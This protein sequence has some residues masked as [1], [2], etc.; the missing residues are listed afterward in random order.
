MKNNSYDKKIFRLIYILNRLSNRERIIT[1]NLAQEFN[2]TIRTVQRD[3]EL[4]SMTGFPLSLNNGVYKFEE[5]F[6][7]RKISVTPEEKFLLMLFYQ[8]FS[9]TDKPLSTTA[10]NL[11]DKVLV[12][13][14]KKD[15]FF[16]ELSSQYKKRVLKE[17]F[18]N[19]SDSLAVRLEDCTYP[20]L[21]I[22]KIDAFIIELKEKIEALKSEDKVNIKLE[23][24]HRYENNKPIAVVNVPKLY[25]KDKTAKFD[26]LLKEKKDREFI[27]ETHLPG[28]FRK[29]FR[30]SLNLHMSFNFWGTHFKS[31]DI[32]CF[33]EFADYLGFPSNLKM[34]NYKASYGNPD[35]KYKFL[36]TFADVRWEKEID[37]PISE[38]KP[39]LNK[40]S[41]YPRSQ[42]WD[43]RKRK[44][45]TKR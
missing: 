26:F 21:F 18:N 28:K 41:G 37:M 29:G 7:L 36:V 39:F 10:K 17:E 27:I 38:L 23:F 1:A 12:S 31:K 30:M 2:V 3:L 45:T 15:I 5:G 8:L 4:L 35:K 44:W 22:K 24:T 16:N 32:T 40:K 43:A 6:S 33:D 9:Q 20:K 19:F 42:S 11:L 25:F 14:D 34:F 13:A